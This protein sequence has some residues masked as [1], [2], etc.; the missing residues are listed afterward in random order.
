MFQQ[1][2]QET[3]GA[4]GPDAGTPKHRHEDLATGYTHLYEAQHCPACGHS[5]CHGCYCGH[6][7]AEA[8]IRTNYQ[9]NGLIHQP[10]GRARLDCFVE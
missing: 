1:E 9:P 4:S 10:N 6:P 7:E 3:S 5:V 8:L 2:G